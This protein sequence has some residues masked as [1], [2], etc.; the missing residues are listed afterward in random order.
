MEQ[1]LGNIIEKLLRQK[2]MSVRE[3]ANEINYTPQAVYRILKQ[4][5]M[6]PFLLEVISKALDHN[7][8]QYVYLPPKEMIQQNESE[9]FKKLRKENDDLKKENAYLK[10][11]NELLKGKKK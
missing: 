7:L 2:P 6:H 11:I 5:M 3:L 10:E 9:E 1:H 8:F 4:K